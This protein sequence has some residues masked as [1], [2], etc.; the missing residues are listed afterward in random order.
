MSDLNKMASGAS[1]DPLSFCWRCF[2]RWSSGDAM[3]LIRTVGQASSRRL[4]DEE[5]YASFWERLHADR[6]SVP[7][8]PEVDF[9]EKVVVAI[10][11]GRRST[12][13]YGVE[14]DE[15]LASDGGGRIQVQF[16]ETV[17][18]NDCVVTQALTSPYVLATVEAQD[19]DLT[20]EGA[21][22]TRSC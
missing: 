13:G 8:R 22:E 5:T 19:E 1:R 2:Y 10:V 16:A 18:G 7:D 15:V 4:R 11:L 17:P 6:N 9:E 21:E 12:G 14:I 20:F 3:G